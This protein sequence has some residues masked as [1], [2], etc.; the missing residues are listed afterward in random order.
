MTFKYLL[1]TACL[2]TIFTIGCVSTSSVIVD[3]NDTTI[4][5]INDNRISPSD[6][7]LITEAAGRD[8]LSAP[9]FAEYL[10]AYAIDAQ[11]RLNDAAAKGEKITAREKL[12]SMKPLLM[13]SSIKNYTDEHIDSKLLTEKLRTI[14]FNSGKVR[15]TTYAAGSG[16]D[17]DEASADARQLKYDPNVK[18]STIMKKNSV[19]AYDLSLSGSIIKQTAKDGRARELSYT[20]NLTLTDSATGEGVWTCNKEIKRQHTQGVFGW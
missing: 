9:L 10:Q 4:G 14:L 15:F 7:V 5:V 8:L 2:F 16:Q 3:P 13:L 1:L 17:I 20:F 12:N 6:W 19:N 18:K 11:E